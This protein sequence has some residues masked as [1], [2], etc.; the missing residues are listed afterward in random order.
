MQ[1]L[2]RLICLVIFFESGFP[3][4]RAAV[5]GELVRRPVDLAE[6]ASAHIRFIYAIPFDGQDNQ[7][8][9]NGYLAA[10]IQSMQGWIATQL[11][12]S[13]LR[14]V[15]HADSPEILF[16]RLRLMDVDIAKHGRR[17]RD[18]IEEALIEDRAIRPDE[19]YVVFYDGAGAGVCGDAPWN[20]LKLTR[21]AVIYLNGTAGRT[22]G[23]P[24]C[25]PSR[26]K[27]SGVG[28]G[29]FEFAT[30]HEILHLLGFV[31]NCA[32]HYTP[33]GH[34]GDDP[35]DLMYAGPERW[36]PSRI[37]VNRDDYYLHGRANC[38]DLA[39]S[40]FLKRPSE[41]LQPNPR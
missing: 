10:A 30:A 8:D 41:A 37:D 22:P 15:Q 20:G 38:P 17:I 26:V 4:D 12:G 7:L 28:P 24:R 1:L 31:A 35:T 29:Y 19:R 2:A 11:A 14:I 40:A 3:I 32:P 21:V 39:A 13:N 6:P 9:L 18:R 36:R 16:S 27:A 33:D 5:A 34:V 23:N 25:T